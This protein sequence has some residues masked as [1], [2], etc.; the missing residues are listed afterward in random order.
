MALGVL[1]FVQP[2][3]LIVDRHYFQQVTYVYF[4][5]AEYQSFLALTALVLTGGHV[6]VYPTLPARG[7][8]WPLEGAVLVE[9]GAE[10][11]KIVD[12]C[13]HLVLDDVPPALEVGVDQH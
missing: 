9:V 1:H 4:S 11:K 6:R 3:V 10:E 8:L 2:P 13:D 7:V 5:H 12:E